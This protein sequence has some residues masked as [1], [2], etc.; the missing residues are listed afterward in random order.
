METSGLKT[1]LQLIIIYLISII[2]TIAYKGKELDEDDISK[3][4]LNTVFL[5]YY[6]VRSDTGYIPLGQVHITQPFTE[7]HVKTKTHDLICANEHRLFDKN[8]NEIFVDKLKV[9]QLIQTENGLE[10]VISVK[11]GWK[12]YSMF[13]ISVYNHN[14]RYY[15]NGILSHQTISSSIFIAWYL[16]F[17]I[18]KNAL[19]LSNKLDTTKEI[20]DKAKVI[21][22][23]LPWFMKPGILK[24]DVTN[25]KFDN[26]CRLVGQS[27]TSKAGISFTIH[28]LFLDEFAHVQANIVESFFENVYPTLSSSLIS[29]III[30]S[31]PNGYNKFFDIYDSAMKGDNEFHPYKVDWWQ[32]PG[33]DDAWKEREV[34]M[35][36]GGIKGEE[37]F[38]RQ[39]GN[40]FIASSSLLLNSVVLKKMDKDMKQYVYHEFDP[41]TDAAL[42][43]KNFLTWHPNFD[44]ESIESESNYWV[45]SIDIA[46][47]NGGDNSVINM[48]Q[49]IPMNKEEIK[50]IHGPGAMYDF[51][52]LKQ[53]GRFSSNE[54]GLED[55]AKVLYILNYDL[56]YS[57]NVKLI[58]EYNAYGAV[59][60]NYLSTVFPQ[61][62]DFDEESVVKFKHR[63]D[64][65]SLSFGLKIK[66]DNKPILCQNFKKVT[67]LNRMD[68]TD[69]MTVYEISKFG[70][71]SNG[72][73]GGQT[74]NDDL[75]M[76]SINC[77]EFV[78]TVDYAD[79]IEELLDIID[80]NL[81]DYM[82]EI[83]YKGLDKTGADLHYDIYDLLKS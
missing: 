59:M 5:E 57:E 71:L 25:M 53:V 64:A 76:S 38:N 9:G 10:E 48:F 35:L 28:L 83:L 72:S 63:H 52:K 20:I 21:I 40:Q 16:I 4:I 74:G 23:N 54:H 75:A 37:A 2:E 66:K 69:K 11:R 1:P 33:R 8:M 15:S 26:G 65:K 77:A 81:H 61:R 29:R 78:N 58:L 14:H 34:G 80:D 32:V 67:E 6:F 82:E 70:K 56:F 68:L 19:I 55:F 62:N 13:D 30:T 47:G 22:E 39:Y 7:W 3:K 49:V 73:Y 18:D 41:F 43:V 50:E 12:K 24:Y 60:M 31:T 46:E 17:N 27:T 36:G 45:F 44:I 51:F 42:D 79:F